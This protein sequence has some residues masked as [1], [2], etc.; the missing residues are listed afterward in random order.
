MLWDGVLL[1]TVFFIMW[2][3]KQ[4][5]CLSF[6]R[7]HRKITVLVW[8]DAFPTRRRRG[9]KTRFFFPLRDLCAS[10]LDIALLTARW[11][12]WGFGVKVMLPSLLGDAEP[13]EPPRHP[14][15]LPMVSAPAEG[16]LNRQNHRHLCN[17]CLMSCSLGNCEL[18]FI[19]LVEYTCNLNIAW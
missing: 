15:A 4:S 17:I 6:S 11:L 19:L 5:H 8:A 16:P 14:A 13:R 12:G 9:R 7:L 2:M 1:C 18:L 3:K 10:Q